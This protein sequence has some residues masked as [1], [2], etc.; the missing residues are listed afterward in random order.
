MSIK[1][2]CCLC[3]TPCNEYKSLQN[4]QGEC[5]EFYEITVK[6]F[7]PMLLTEYLNT[8][9]SQDSKILC[10]ECWLHIH[11]FHEFQQNVIKTRSLLEETEVKQLPLQV[12]LEDEHFASRQ[13]DNEQNLDNSDEELT[14]FEDILIKNDSDGD[15]LD[16]L[17][18]NDEFNNDNKAAEDNEDEDDQKPLIEFRKTRN[19]SHTNEINVEEAT[20]PKTRRGRKPKEIT[21]P[22]AIMT[23]DEGDESI[24]KPI[25]KKRK[26]K[27]T[28]KP[29]KNPRINSGLEKGRESDEFIAEWKPLLECDICNETF[30]VFELLKG[31]FKTTH[32]TRCYIKCC[33]RKFFRRCVLVDHIRLHI[34]PETHKCDIC[35]KPSSSKYNLKLH[36]KVVHEET[37][38]FE[39]EVCHRSFNQKPNLERH[40]LTHVTGSKDFICKEC[41]KGYVLEV[42]LKSH[43]KTVHSDN[44][45]CDQC[46]K[47]LHGIGALKKHLMEH[48]G[49]ERPKYPCD[50]CGAQ[51]RSRGN[52][53]RHKAAYHNDGK[54]IYVCSICGKVAAS[55]YGLLTHKKHVHQEERKHKCTY[56]DKAFKRPKFLRE[57]IAT[58]TGEDLYQCPHCPQTFKVSS[59]MHH[60]RKKAHPVE[61][62]E[63]RKNRLQLRKVD[64]TQV[65]NQVVI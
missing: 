64:I 54:T 36:K 6:Y 34:N 1:L 21:K 30:P 28:E 8:K 35:G 55:E 52:L 37:E 15:D 51:L 16:V 12:K 23:D 44:R 17:R 24:D 42:Q 53:R 56:C 19:Q 29:K 14:H 61:F 22:I 48:A 63:G 13:S 9:S 25:K 4:D 5:N 39:C 60:H 40:L 46:G 20:K 41:G 27:D 49:I 45:V 7:D 62:E 59:N 57:H 11:D 65:T 58:H 10:V 2:C 43:I 38:Q 26:F 47:T 50:E 18:D 31:H 33:E 3:C 32:N